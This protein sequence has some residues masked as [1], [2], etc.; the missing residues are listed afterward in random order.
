MTQ[1]TDVKL[2]LR[3]DLSEKASERFRAL[4][5]YYAVNADAELV[6]ILISEEFRRKFGET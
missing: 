1:N 3:V 2:T 5:E 4:K 6:R